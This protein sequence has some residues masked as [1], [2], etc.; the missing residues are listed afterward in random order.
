MPVRYFNQKQPTRGDSKLKIIMIGDTVTKNLTVYEY[1][2]SIIAVDYGIGFP[3]DDEMG[4]DFII[5]DMS[6]L[7]E[8]QDRLKGIFISHA[9]ADHFAALPF[10]LQELDNVPIYGNRLVQGLLNKQLE[11]K[12]YKGLQEK[13]SFHLFNASVEEVVFGDF[14]VSAFGVNHSVPGSL[15]IA[16]N[17]P[18]GLVLHMADFKVDEGP[19]LDKPIDLAKIKEYGEKGVICLLSDSLGAGSQGKVPSED[20]LNNTF[21]DI[22]RKYDENQLYITTISSN[23]SRMYQIIDA[24]VKVGRKVVPIGRSIEQMVDV[25]KGIGYLPFPEDAYLS[26]GEATGYDQKTVVYLIAGCYGQ[27]GS[28]L[29]RLSRGEHD[30]LSLNEGAVVVFSS[31]PNPPGV[32]V[33]VERACSN[34]ILMGAE[35]VDYKNRGDLHISG[36]GHAEDL[37]MIIEASKPKYFIPIGGTPRQMRDY[38][39]LVESM[40]ISK[41]KVF[42][43]QEGES[44]EFSHGNA[45]RGKTVE[46]TDIYIDGTEVDPV[47]IRDREQLS[48]DGVFVVVVPVH[49]KD[50]VVAGK[51]DIVTRG[52][53]YVKESQALM[54]RSRDM[55]NK[56]LAKNQGKIQDWNAV[57]NIIEKRMRKF[58]LK[59]TGRRPIII[60]HS[61]FV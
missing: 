13:M 52:F 6:Y 58:L 26:K 5:P 28:S 45:K 1:G 14:R 44:V 53:V 30:D 8:N 47:V 17:T 34:L 57:K 21:P 25:A 18:E 41:E 2:D 31:E 29:D 36:H 40:G 38:T 27:P 32:D 33:D 12:K 35:I 10:L 9:H 59:E 61:I 46:V 60:V 54:G 3:E 23:V 22:F 48:S 16:I 50:R 51:V 20:T 55:V 11:E 49:K 42:E 43:L 24:A 7:L 39:H 37:K 56:I 15:G 19:V 4:V